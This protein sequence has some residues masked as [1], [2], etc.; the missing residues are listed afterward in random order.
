VTAAS[1]EEMKAL[2][3]RNGYYGVLALPPYI[4]DTDKRDATLDDVLDHI[5]HAVVVM[6]VDKVGI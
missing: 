2:A 4:T 5:D 1:D 6:D 3:A